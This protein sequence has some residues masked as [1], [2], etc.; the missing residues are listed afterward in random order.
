[1]FRKE[2]AS[3]ERI[4]ATYDVHMTCHLQPIP[5]RFDSLRQWLGYTSM[6]RR[7]RYCGGLAKT[8]PNWLMRSPLYRPAG[9]T[10]AV[11]P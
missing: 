1:M 4:S 11:Q 10:C 7:F 8:W 6:L 3:H 9:M 2:F 5:V